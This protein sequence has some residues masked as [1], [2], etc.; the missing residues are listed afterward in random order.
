M[1]TKL[2]LIVIAGV[3]ITGCDFY[4]EDFYKE[5]VPV[6]IDYTMDYLPGQPILVDLSAFI[7]QGNSKSFVIR[8][9]PSV[10]T[11]EIL[12][13]SFMVY[14]PKSGDSD[15]LIVD[16]FDS[17]NSKIG[18]ARINLEASSNAC[19]IAKFD[20]AE[21]EPGGKLQVNLTDNDQFCAPIHS[22]V[23]MYTPVENAEGLS[24]AIP[25]KVN[26]A[27]PNEPIRIE[28][29]YTAPEGFKGIAKGLYVAGINI[30]EEYRNQDFEELML[31]PAEKFEYF[32][33]S[34]V[35]IKVE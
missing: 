11:A 7:D 12:A 21:V 1:K 18:E 25:V 8:N 33:A 23:T 27:D 30:K 28:L 31:N 17:K 34:L 13:E 4:K 16:V 6:I 10:G 20:Y 35:E 2:M 19:G 14:T 26:P 9:S 3:L 22:A 24:V 29:R 5:D 15:Q 32:V